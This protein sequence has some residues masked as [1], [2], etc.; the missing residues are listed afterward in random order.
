[1]GWLLCNF[2]ANELLGPANY[3]DKI[4]LLSHGLHLQH[5]AETA[6]KMLKNVPNYK[7]LINPFNNQNISSKN[8]EKIGKNNWEKYISK[9]MWKLTGEN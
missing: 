2:W 9:L 3:N 5:E 7:K 8:L 1:M 4:V 6:I